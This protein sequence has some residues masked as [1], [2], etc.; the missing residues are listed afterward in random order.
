L[1]LGSV[2]ALAWGYLLYMGWGMEHME[3]GV[4]MAIMPRMTQWGTIDLLLV[5][6]MWV[7]MMSRASMESILPLRWASR[8][9]AT[10]D[11]RH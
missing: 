11:R 1:G 5:F 3:V 8:L 4:N 9:R 2:V 7:V 6:M 10:G